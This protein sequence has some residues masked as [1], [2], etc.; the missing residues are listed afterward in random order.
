MFLNQLSEDELKLYLR[1]AAVLTA[2][3]NP[4]VNKKEASLFPRFISPGINEQPKKEIL[5]IESEISLLKSS[6]CSE[7]TLREAEV[8]E[9]IYSTY[10]DFE[11]VLFAVDKDADPDEAPLPEADRRLALAAKLARRYIRET[12]LVSTLPASSKVIV[13]E[14]Y[15]VGLADGEIT[16][17]EQALITKL[18]KT[19]Q[20]QHFISLDLQESA[21]S[22]NRALIATLAIISE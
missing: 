21:K 15:A 4:I 20:V 5:R 8:E 7:S 12:N 18:A 13:F 19:L 22:I 6:V 1:L 10:E 17:A 11:S 14:L 2:I 9:I 16:D 3:D